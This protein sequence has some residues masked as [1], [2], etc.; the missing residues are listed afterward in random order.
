MTSMG[1]RRKSGFWT[2][3]VSRNARAAS[4]FALRVGR[5]AVKQSIS[6]VAKPAAVARKSANR[7]LVATSGRWL[8]GTAVGS[9]GGRRYHL[10][11]PAGLSAGDH[12]PLLVMLHGC[13]QDGLGFA[14]STRMNAIAQRERFLVLYP[15]QDLLAN[16]QGC[17]NWFE[18]RS[19]RAQVE[20]AGVV[21]AVDQ[22]IGRHRADASRVAI[23]G[24]S[25]GA[26]MAALVAVRHPDR[27]AAVAMHSG[28]R[29]GAAQSTATALAAMR[30]R[31]RS[32]A[33]SVPEF[34]LPPLL[35]IQGTADPIVV[36]ANARAAAHAWACAGDAR[37]PSPVRESAERRVQRG[38][39][40]P[41]HIVDF[42][43]RTSLVATL[44][45][46][47]GLGH[48]WSGGATGQPYSD[49]SGPDMSRLI[50]AFA[51]KQFRSAQA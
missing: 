23:C 47:D 37:D 18:T 2:S 14:R 16:A 15:E 12:P 9:A 44:V 31:G 21:A 51:A 19:G 25:A 3:I 42:K 46:I 11:V 32:K 33:W 17:W 43:R 45:E 26:S 28:V 8:A 34:A 50:W 35:V 7:G 10:F 13:G 36:R 49:P 4:Q 20:A 5:A 27:F 30:G 39:R 24:L 6:R 41:M 29:P 38:S 1:K 22:V 40:K 48:A